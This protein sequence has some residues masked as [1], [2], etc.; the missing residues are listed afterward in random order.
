[1]SR[2]LGSEWPLCETAEVLQRRRARRAVLADVAGVT[3]SVAAFAAIT[4]LALILAPLVG[5]A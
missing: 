5:I 3:L 2:M 1:V 4:P